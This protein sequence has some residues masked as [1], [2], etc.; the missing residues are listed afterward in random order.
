MLNALIPHID[1]HV[2][3]FNVKYGLVERVTEVDGDSTT[4]FPARYKG[5]DEYEAVDF[6]LQPSYHRMNGQRTVAVTES[7]LTGCS[8]G[9]TITYPM[10]MVGCLEID[11]EDQYRFEQLS[12]LV[13]NDII[14]VEFKKIRKQLNTLS[15]ELN[16][17][18]INSDR[19]AVWA[20]E[21]EGAAMNIPFK[22][23][24]FSI[25]YEL[26]IIADSS[27]LNTCCS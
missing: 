25:G 1:C 21:N 3:R 23:T 17:V 12:N 16:V 9:V 27:C 20:Q 18:N 6:E 19:N 15:I 5:A 26:V 22:Y 4:T 10:V 24:L 13:A 11:R 7:N 14:S 2:N 8:K